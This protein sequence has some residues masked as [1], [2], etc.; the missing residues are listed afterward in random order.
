MSILPTWPIAAGCSVIALAVGLAVGAGADHLWMAPKV[1]KITKDYNDLVT[2]NKEAARVAQVKRGD[3]ER[4]ARETEKAQAKVVAQIEQEKQDAIATVRSD[5]DALI[6]RLRKQAASK[7][8]N[9]GGVP[10]AGPACQSAAG[11]EFSDSG[12]E[13]LVRLAERADQQ[14]AALGACYQAYD[15][16]S[17][18][19]D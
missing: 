8:A 5:A 15:S 9:P 10:S 14:R 18:E 4:A 3:D 2:S 19:Q 13:D 12:R 7:P 6:A 11:G 17:S 16:V 1:A